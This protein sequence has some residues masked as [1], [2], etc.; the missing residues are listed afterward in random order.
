MILDTAFVL[1]LLAGDEGATEKAEEL[2]VSGVAMKMPAMAVTELYIGVGT[3]VANER[4]ERRIRGIIESVP[5]VPM[6]LQLSRRAGRMVGET[7]TDV[8]KGDAAIAAVAERADEPVLTRNVDD[9]EELGVD[10]ETY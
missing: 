6:D 10:I 4:E 9:F 8:G 1:D 3:G 2:E 7:G 5:F